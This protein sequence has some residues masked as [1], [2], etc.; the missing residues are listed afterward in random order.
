MKHINDYSLYLVTS[1]E[2]SAGRSSFEVA[3]AAI[4]GGVDIIQMREKN[5]SRQDLIK[6][7]KKLAKLS[8]KGNIAFIANDDPFIALEIDADGVHLGQEDLKRY[9]IDKTREILGRDKLIGLSTHSLEE[10]A[11][12]NKLDINYIAFGP[13]FTTKTKTYSISTKDVTKAVAL[14]K[15]PVVGI[16]GINKDNIKEVLNLGAKNIALIR[17]IT[18]S[19]DIAAKVKEL[20][21]IITSYLEATNDSDH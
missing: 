21:R 10:V 18:E 15:F 12:A 13:L 2:Y 8:K 11:Y 9:S 17:G 3:Q 19:K 7:G 5:L 6:L 20:K 16:G 1:Q 4:D 14:S